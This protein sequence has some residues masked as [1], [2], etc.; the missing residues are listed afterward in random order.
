MEV[1]I[2][3]SQNNINLRIN[4]TKKT[5]LNE[6]SNTDV[7]RY[8]KGIL[9]NRERFISR[10]IKPILNVKTTFKNQLENGELVK[11]NEPNVEDWECTDFMN[12][13]IEIYD[14]VEPFTYLEAF[15]INDL[16]FQA[17]V[18]GSI[19]IVSMIKELG[20]ERIKTEG[21][22]VTHKQF[23]QEGNF[24]G[25]KDYDVIYETH[26]IN[27]EKLRLSEDLYAIKCWCTST[28]KEHWLWIDEEFKNKPLEAIASTFQIHENLIPHI[29]ELKRQG[30][31][32]LVEMDRDI[33][34]SGEIV[35][36]NSEQYFSL[37]TA[38]S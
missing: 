36:L 33:E 14:V 5:L 25:Y 30:D 21:K 22:L 31:V 9:R 18:F 20:N 6:V 35:S 2:E 4:L 8:V 15:E 32:L 13:L 37:L 23:D 11:F 7:I 10:F 12:E 16:D 38:Q 1:I 29:K 34:P 27:G 24:I 26:K 28:D 17:L 3:Y 19:D